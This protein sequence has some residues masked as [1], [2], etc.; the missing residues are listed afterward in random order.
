MVVKRHL[1]DTGPV[2]GLVEMSETASAVVVGSRGRTGLKSLI[3]SVSRSVLEHA[4]ST[5]VIVRPDHEAPAP[6]S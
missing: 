3:G 1:P 6:T 5:V 2:A 4:H